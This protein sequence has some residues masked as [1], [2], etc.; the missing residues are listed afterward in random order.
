MNSQFRLCLFILLTI[1]FP[2]QADISFT[3]EVQIEAAGGMAMFASTGEVKTSISGDK[4]R[5]QSST[6]MKSKLMGKLAGNGSS[7]NIVRLDKALT[8][9]LEPE[10][11]RYSELTFAQIKEQL[12][13]AMSSVEK[14]QTSSDQSLPVSSEN[15]SWSESDISLEHPKG[16]EKIA[17]IKTSKHTIRLHQ[18]CSDPETG[19]TCELTW[20]MDTW[21]ARKVPGE[22]E[23]L[24][25]RQGYA[26]AIGMDDLMQ[27]VQGPGQGLLRMFSG[28]WDELL[29]EFEKL[30]GYPLRTVMQMG[31]GG[32]QC[33]TTS[34]NPI[35]MDDVWADA[36]TAAYN[37]AL[38]QAGSQASRAIGRSA[39]EAMGTSVA[40]SIG[41][42]AVGAAA[43]ELI[44]GLSGMFKKKK[45]KKPAVEQNVKP[46]EKQVT[47]F[48]IET[49]VTSWSKDS[50]PAEHFEEP[51]GWKK[52]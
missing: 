16:K 41:G 36:S 37:A 45:K 29:A 46:E 35:S 2:A 44:G 38:G 7:T 5:T 48:R 17:G 18:S 21:L 8:W 28:N 9:N 52:Y 43:G 10:K 12:Q 24:A 3:Q 47:V 4:S 20:V 51:T 49:Q 42:A 34:G 27:Q 25:F 11:Q 33:T 32:E 50:I 14:A 31:I 23:V 30:K 22:K 13:Q 15:C 6:K 1:V 40:G 26:T 19:N 39:G